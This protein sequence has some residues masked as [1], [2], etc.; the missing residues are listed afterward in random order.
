MRVFSIVGASVLA[1]VAVILGFSFSGWALYTGGHGEPPGWGEWF[2]FAALNAILAAGGGIL[3][4]LSGLFLGWLI[5]R[6][7]PTQRS[8]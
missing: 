4:G 8:T 5:E 3:G 2:G 1:I 6:R 7:R